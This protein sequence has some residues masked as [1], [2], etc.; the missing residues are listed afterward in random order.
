MNQQTKYYNKI[1][2]E[3]DH[4]RFSNSYGQY[5]DAQEKKVL[6]KL[7]KGVNKDN[8]LDLG[9]GTG[10]LLDFANIG[11]DPSMEMI[12]IAKNKYPAKKIFEENA[13]QTHFKENTFDIDFSFNVFIHLDNKKIIYKLN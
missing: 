8:I 9:C 1:A 4:S 2:K 3:Y 6:T 13:T 10:R 11:L 5:I 7:L 12:D